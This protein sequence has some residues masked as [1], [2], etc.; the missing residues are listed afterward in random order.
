MPNDCWNNLTI[1]SHDDPDE[2]DNLIQNEFKHLDPTGEYVYNETIEPIVRGRRGIR[3]ILTTSWSPDF[4]W[5]EGLLT[6]YPSCW[7][8]NEWSE[9]GGFAGVWVGCING[10]EQ[11]IKHL[12]WA[13]ICIEGKHEY[14]YYNRNNEELDEEHK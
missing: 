7:I 11:E 14:F 10:N 3:V 5:L 4:E 9:E 12:E 13:D 6:K 2:L 1:T 8:K